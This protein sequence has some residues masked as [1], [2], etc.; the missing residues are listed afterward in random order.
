MKSPRLIGFEA[1]NLTNRQ[2]DSA[3]KE[4]KQKAEDVHVRK[5]Q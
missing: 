5:I 3:G 2:F 1:W 4:Y